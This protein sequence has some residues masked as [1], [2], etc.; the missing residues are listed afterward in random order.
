MV[1]SVGCRVCSLVAA[2]ISLVLKWKWWSSGAVLLRVLCY[3]CDDALQLHI[4]IYIQGAS[5]CW[6][7]AVVVYATTAA[8][9]SKPSTLRFSVHYHW[10]A[11]FS[12]LP[13]PFSLYHWHSLWHANWIHSLALSFP[14]SHSTCTG[15]SSVLLVTPLPLILQTNQWRWRQMVEQR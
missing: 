8:A 14:F 11:P 5:E 6:S 2:S 1:W 10:L 4:Y 7:A 13:S 15:C 12:L 3:Y 9:A